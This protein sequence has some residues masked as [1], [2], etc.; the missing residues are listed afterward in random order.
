[1]MSF[2][3]VT[4]CWSLRRRYEASYD[5][6]VDAASPLGQSQR[7]VS[8]SSSLATSF[9]DSL[10]HGPPASIFPERGGWGGGKTAVYEL[11][12][13]IN[14]LNC[15]DVEITNFNFAFVHAHL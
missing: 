10:Q 8:S 14:S 3:S 13:H 12:N 15:E 2:D 5:V 7:V 11:Q 4:R 6:T 1:M 9:G